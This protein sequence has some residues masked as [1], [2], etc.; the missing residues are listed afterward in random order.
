[1]ALK[2]TSVPYVILQVTKK[3]TTKEKKYSVV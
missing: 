2:F 1:M 3:K